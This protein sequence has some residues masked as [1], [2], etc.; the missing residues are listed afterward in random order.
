MPPRPNLNKP[1]KNKI[2]YY[3]EVV[4]PEPFVID[5]DVTD[6]NFISE[7]IDV[8]NQSHLTEFL[9]DNIQ[10]PTNS[11][12]IYCQESELKKMIPSNNDEYKY[13]MKKFDAGWVILIFDKSNESVGKG[14]II[15]LGRKLPKNKTKLEIIKHMENFTTKLNNGNSRL[16]SLMVKVEMIKTKIEETGCNC[17]GNNK[18]YN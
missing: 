9:R 15:K 17:G 13:K 6:E 7:I 10:K 18:N 1:P 2:F 16:K 5:E 3:W 8:S 4:A 14:E 11:F 12:V